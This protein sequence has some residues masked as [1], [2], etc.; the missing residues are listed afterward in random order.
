MTRFPSRSALA[1][2][3]VP[4]VTG[5]CGWVD[6]TGRQA[7]EETGGDAR[8]SSGVPVPLLESVPLALLEEDP[9]EVRL[10]GEDAALV[11]WSWRALEERAEPEACAAVPGFD[12]AI[13]ERRLADACSDPARC[14]IGVDE[15]V[16]DGETRFDL[17]LPALRAPV[18]AHVSLSA[19]DAE[20]RPV[21]RRRTLCGLS[22]NEAPEALDDR[23]SVAPGETLVV[24]AGDPSSLL[25]NDVDDDDVRNAPLSIDPVPVRPPSHAAAFELGTDG[26]L[27]YRAPDDP[28][29][30]SDGVLE[31]SFSYRL[32][33]GLHEVIA[34]VV[35]VI[36]AVN[37]PPVAN[38]P[39]PDVEIAVAPVGTRQV[40]VDLAPFFDDPDGDDLAFAVVPGSL[41]PGGG[42]F[43]DERGVLGGRAGADDLG[44][45]RVTLVVDD[46]RTSVER[47]F[48][49]DVVRAF[50]AN[51]APTVTDI[52]N[53]AVRGR[54]RYDVSP[55]FDD[56]DGDRLRFSAVGLPNGVGIDDDGRIE[57][58]AR[59]RNRGNWFVIVT[60]ED[61]RGGRVSDGFRLTIE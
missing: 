11:G 35:V 34:E 18:V 9:R 39:L 14:A 12:A 30:G 27:L 53:R 3:L 31:D 15:R 4:L 38:A 13:A 41:P 25:G 51:A 43:V 8:T 61:G 60:A 33:D 16:V 20:G 26:S 42:L 50:E 45:W 2:L 48:Q 6:A 22:I 56:A 29:L 17:T 59:N 24:R 47:D 1:T 10:D 32:T 21:E 44:S 57:G 28:P 37:R 49:L 58:R 52:D 19:R 7:D 23:L 46:G 5:G 55:F 40:R 54:F 36:A